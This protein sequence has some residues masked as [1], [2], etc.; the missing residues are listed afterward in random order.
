MD[1]EAS[2]QQLAKLRELDNPSARFT[3]AVAHRDQAVGEALACKLVSIGYAH[4]AVAPLHEA[5]SAMSIEELEP[6]FS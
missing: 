6:L 5:L 4:L 1:P 2:E 3:V